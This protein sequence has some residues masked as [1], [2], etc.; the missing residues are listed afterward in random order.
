[1]EELEQLASGRVCSRVHARL[2]AVVELCGGTYVCAPRKSHERCVQKVEQE[3]LGDYGKLLD[4]ERATGL[5]EQAEDML[6]CL[7]MLRG[8]EKEEE[9]GEQGEQEG[10]REVQAEVMV[11]MGQSSCSS[12]S[13]SPSSSSS[14]SPPSSSSSSSAVSLAVVRCKDRVSS[15]LS[16][17]YRDLLLNVCEAG[18]GFIMELQ[19]NFNKIA[20]INSK[21]H[22]FYELMRVMEIKWLLKNILDS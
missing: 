13:F 11:H 8:E 4:L 2:K 17:G 7:K 12:S 18:S 20:Q 15:P 9:Q 16:S 14:S 1:M 19:L 3:Y 6:R 10:E 22:R 21:T 5:F